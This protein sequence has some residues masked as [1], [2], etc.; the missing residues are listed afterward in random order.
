MKQNYLL[1]LVLAGLTSLP[2]QAQ[3]NQFPKVWG[4]Q[5]PK[6]Q[7]ALS[8]KQLKAPSAIDDKSKG[9]VVYAGERMDESKKRSFIKFN[10]KEN[11]KF[12]R[13]KHYILNEKEEYEQNF[14][15]IM[16]AYDGKDYYAIFGYSFTYSNQG[17][18]L[19]KVDMQTGDTTVVRTFSKAE[20]DS[21]YGDGVYGD[22][23]TA[24]YDMAYD[25]NTN[26]LYALGYGWADDG[27]YGF[28]KLYAVDREKGTWD[29]VTDFDC[30]YYEFCFDYD[31]NM[32]ATRPKAGKDGETN[33]G[34]ELVKLDKDFNEISAKELTD[35]WGG[36]MVLAQFGALGVDNATNTLYWMPATQWGA[37]SL[38]TINPET[39]QYTWCN[40][41]Y[42]GNWFTGFYIP[43]LAAD[44]RGA[45]ARVANIDVTA[46][47]NGAMAD[48]LKWVNPT[49]TWGGADLDAI[50]EVRIYRKKA[51]VA[52][53]DLTPTSELLS[54]ENADL[55][56]T[57]PADGKLGEAMQ[58]VDEKPLA[59]INTYYV[60]PSRVEGEIGVPDSIRCYMGVDVPGAVPYASLE[61]KG[62]GLRITWGK[63]DKGNTNGYINPD[64]VTYKLTRMPDNVVV[65]EN[66]EG[67]EFEDYTL[68]EQ[69]KYY[70]L[71]Q[72]KNEA[73]EG[74]VYT[75]DGVMAGTALTT[76]IDLKFEN[77]DDASRWNLNFF[78]NTYS[79][80]YGGW[81][82]CDDKYKCLV[83]YPSGSSYD[84]STLL[85]P[86]LKLQA[87]KSYR[88]V[89]KFYNNYEGPFSLKLTMGKNSEDLS[90]ATVIHEEE[91]A[92]YPSFTTN[93]YED[94]FTAPEDGIYY[95]GLTVTS[96][97]GYN[98]FKFYGLTID[99][100][101][102]NDLKAFSMGNIIE[103]VAGQENKCTVKVRNM[104]YNDQS[105][106][107]IKIYC[108][109]GDEKTLVGETTDVPAIKA[110][111][112]ADVTAKFTP[113]KDGKYNFYAEVV[114]EGDEDASNNATPEISLNVMPEGSTA[115]SNVATS[116]K[117]EG[118]DTHGPIAYSS[119]YDHTESI[120]YPSEI[121]GNDGDMITRIGYMYD[122]NSNLTDR[123]D[124][125]NIKIYMG[126]TDQKNFNNG[127]E[128]AI[129]SDQ[130][131]LVYDGTMYLEPG[132]GNLL[133]FDLD[134]PFKYDS[135]KNLAVVVDREG[136]VESSLWF[137]ALFHVF[138][139]NWSSNEYRSLVFGEDYPF[140]E[141]MGNNYSSAPI[142]YLAMQ[143][144]T[145]INTTKTLGG[146]FNYDSNSGVISF[147]DGVK[148]AAVYTLDGKLVKNVAGKAQKLNLSNGIYVV[149]VQTADGKMSNMKL[150]VAK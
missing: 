94:M 89:S 145:G 127:V 54:A 125:S 38:Y 134:T 52:T 114:L 59:G 42:P 66:V 118:T 120:Y 77:N 93:V 132:Q 103:A 97:S 62:E 111:E 46:D 2:M 79:F 81:D 33:E 109:D 24:L 130:L 55:L 147:A 110:G 113:V 51:G 67:T 34:T 117:D 61:K 25:R 98:A 102:P 107:A 19:A 9:I 82:G 150:S 30:I 47:V 149:R 39:A 23:R 116:G 143:S 36:T 48:T 141:G 15:M 87:G 133:A 63:P 40:G 32:Y 14:G 80:Y 8:Q 148:S 44:N 10:S 146:S 121:K 69:K 43:Y 90:D 57:V 13:L 92:E 131:T 21:W 123:T 122:S 139:N 144:A 56:A 53:T 140:E 3:V 108:V 104:G 12:T 20:Q 138:G 91:D 128:D 49:K 70:Y 17:R 96:T 18:F 37:T 115:W 85:S 60:V 129:D 100:V 27:S 1:G 11:G 65:A 68:G 16:G 64:E 142:L 106:Y 74:A 137:C 22:F 71:I 124:E 5:A 135:S 26:T 83:G 6:P 112:Y 28:S 29:L 88:I 50:K 73:G 76:P 119:A 99:Y 7:F 126:Y 41:Y 35:E 31:G 4:Q 84:K 78:D 86:P 75:T 136:A 58:Y 95:Y 101:A 105:K 45:A 72:G